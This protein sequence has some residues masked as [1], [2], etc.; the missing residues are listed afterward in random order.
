MITLVK[1]FNEEQKEIANHLLK[2]FLERSGKLSDCCRVTVHGL[3]EEEYSD[4]ILLGFE[5]D[6]DG[7]TKPTIL[8]QGY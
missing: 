2:E 4:V 8:V 3:K 6:Y 1:D 5:Y 7:F